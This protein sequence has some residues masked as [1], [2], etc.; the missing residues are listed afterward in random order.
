MRRT[1]RRQNNAP[2]ALALGAAG[3]ARSDQTGGER[4]QDGK[5]HSM[6][7]GVVRRQDEAA[8][9][10]TIFNNSNTVILQSRASMI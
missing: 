5:G 4:L 1:L 7:G 10:K 6:A 3:R 8:C 9:G 2:L